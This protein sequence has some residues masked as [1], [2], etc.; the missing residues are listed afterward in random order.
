MLKEWS[1]E[2]GLEKAKEKVF[3]LPPEKQEETKNLQIQYEEKEVQL[4]ELKEYINNQLEEIKKTNKRLGKPSLHS[5]DLSNM[6]MDHVI[7]I[8]VLVFALKLPW[9]SLRTTITAHRTSFLCS[10]AAC[11]GASLVCDHSASMSG[12]TRSS[13]V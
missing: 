12:A 9:C 5:A 1:V 11:C 13:S 6:E 2:K 4:E 7:I 10:H 3:T 8:S